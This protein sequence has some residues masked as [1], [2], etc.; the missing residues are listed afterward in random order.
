MWIA[1]LLTALAWCIVIGRGFFLMQ[2]HEIPMTEK[3]T[4][5]TP[6]LILTLLISLTSLI[7]IIT[8]YT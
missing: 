1:I 3:G 2:N 8:K 6:Y 5:L 4:Q 7:W